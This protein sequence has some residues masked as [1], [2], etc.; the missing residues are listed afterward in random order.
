MKTTQ[1]GYHRQT[2][3]LPQT[4]TLLHD[5]PPLHDFSSVAD[6]PL[7]S[8]LFRFASTR[9]NFHPMNIRALKEFRRRLAL[10]QTTYGLWITLESAS[11]TEF[12]VA[13]GVDWVVVD[14]EH[15][16]LDWKEISQHI[17]AAVRSDTM[18]LVRIAERD[19][20]LAKRALDIGADGIVV[21][22]VETAEQLEE[23]LRDCRYPPQGRRGIGGERATV[24]G[25]CLFEHTAEAN[26]HVL[27][28]PIIESFRAV[29]AVPAMCKVDGAEVFF[30]GPADLSASA[31]YRG[32][33]EGP[34]VAEQIL[35]MKDTMRK[36]GKHCGLLTTGAENLIARR[37]QGFQ[38][39]GLG[40]DTGLLLRSLHESLKAVGRDRR[41]AT[42]LD[43]RDGQAVS[44]PLPRPPEAMRPER[45]EVVTAGGCGPV[46]DLDPGVSMEILVGEFTK[47]RHLTT[48]IVTLQPG[49]A[50]PQHRH[51]CA[52]AITVLTGRVEIAVEGRVYRLGP[53]DNIVIPR[54]LPHVTCNPDP[55]SITR[56]HAALA[57][58]PP[59]RELLTRTFSRVEMPADS[60]GIVGM[61][62]VT[63]FQSAKR[64]FGV[65][66]GAEFIDHFNAELM[67]GLEMS[68]GFGRFQPG[69]R[70][71]AHVHDFDESICIID[72]TATCVVEGRNYSMRGCA[73]TMVPRGRVHYFENRSTTAMD[74]IWVYAGPMPERIVVDSHCATEAGNPWK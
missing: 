73:T 42:S 46:V 65:G 11:L 8:R 57:M 1:T 28:V 2:A 36:A 25:Q 35:Q 39:L 13:L 22:W 23:A 74:M 49:A 24:W 53:L 17:R 58:S 6:G 14:A 59:E 70:L 29:A 43:P 50:L 68:G 20:A 61:E 44:D 21:P 38:M 40:T 67:P 16:C 63:R 66:P 31:G 19:T 12:A 52:E 71:P 30:F 47:V 64:T 34:G 3:D 4:Q 51:P 5:D 15:G 26:E 27:V 62:R 72:G 7:P 32:Q 55:A 9:F 54:W 56:I 18:V 69:G 33:W 37:E 45:V 60:T 10:N 41:P 48:G